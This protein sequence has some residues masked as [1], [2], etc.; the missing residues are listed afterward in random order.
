MIPKWNQPIY[1]INK[2]CPVCWSTPM[3]RPVQ[4][5]CNHVLCNPCLQE[6]MSRDNEESLCPV[7]KTVVVEY[8]SLASKRI[9]RP[10]DKSKPFSENAIRDPRDREY[11]P[12]QG[13]TLENIDTQ[14]ESS[15]SSEESPQSSQLSDNGTQRSASSRSS[16]PLSDRTSSN[17]ADSQHSIA[18]SRP[19]SQDSVT[20]I[21]EY[22]ARPIII[23][24][25]NESREQNDL[26]GDQQEIIYEPI[27]EIEA[28]RGR[29]KSIRYLVVYLNGDKNWEPLSH[30]DYCIQEL[31]KFRKQ[32]HVKNQQNYRLRKAAAKAQGNLRSK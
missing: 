5:Q 32:L 31:V 9:R 29:G 17:R 27:K 20:I 19:H 4:M 11:V 18:G 30:M 28:Y 3:V 22:P 13:L 14:S 24:E 15:E 26:S 21:A 12:P 23:D 6:I 25:N 2:R 1:S 7:C 16:Q 10:R 8:R